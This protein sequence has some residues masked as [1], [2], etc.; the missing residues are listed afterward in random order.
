MSGK[1]HFAYPLTWVTSTPVPYVPSPALPAGTTSGAMA[2]TNVIYTNIIDLTL[3]DNIGLE[4]T[5]SGTPAGFL[6][7]MASIGGSVFYPYVPALTLTQPAGSATGELVSII[8]F[9]YR[10][11][12]LKYTNA[13]GTGAITAWICAKDIN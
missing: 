4:L 13:S 2:S 11:F 8:D 3:F 9:P 7:V 6:V 12:F 1:E 10:Y 5:W